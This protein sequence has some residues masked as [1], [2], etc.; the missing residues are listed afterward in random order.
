M[1]MLASILLTLS[2]PG[3]MFPEMMHSG[4]AKTGDIPLSSSHS[5]SRVQEEK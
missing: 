2:Y 1:I 5:S 4:K 3:Y